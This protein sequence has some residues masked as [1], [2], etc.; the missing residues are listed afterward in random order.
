MT[1]TTLQKP[2]K[3]HLP[4]TPVCESDDDV[5][6][7]LLEMSWLGSLV[8][9]AQAECEREIEAAK[10]KFKQRTKVKIG[11]VE[12]AAADRLSEVEDAVAAYCRNHREELLPDGKKSRK[13][14]HGNIAWKQNPLKLLFREGKD[15]AS[16][17]K[18][19]DASVAGGETLLEFRTRQMTR[20][21]VTDK[22]TSADLIDFGK[23]RLNAIRLKELL[24]RGEIK[25]S[26]LK[27]V[28]LTAPDAGE[29]FD[30]KPH[31]YTTQAEAA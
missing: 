21:K 27:K 22:L 18:K 31:P 6:R 8:A 12:F 9:T 7:G 26:D 25:E 14:P 29:K 13:F 4:A 16:L 11:G 30:A 2:P 17:L 15:L 20:V 1:T 10:E 28:G 19:I 24:K 5:D 23:P 3:N